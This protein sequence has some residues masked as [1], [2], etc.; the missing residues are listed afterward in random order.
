MA[1]LFG[2]S[3]L[4]GASM[5]P[6]E[7]PQE[8]CPGFAMRFWASPF[9]VLSCSLPG[10]TGD[11][12]APGLSIFFLIGT[13]QCTGKLLFPSRTPIIQIVHEQSLLMG[14]CKDLCPKSSPMWTPVLSPH[15]DV[16][17]QSVH[18]LSAHRGIFPSVPAS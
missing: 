13:L 2:R 11:C 8:D 18:K 9:S 6:E 5:H 7:Q 10:H 1:E 4:L 14:L 3:M 17:V 15:W 16:P 12:L